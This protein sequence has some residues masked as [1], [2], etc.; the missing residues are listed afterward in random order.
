MRALSLSLVLGGSKD[1]GLCA[2]E[3][4][5]MTFQVEE[6]APGQLGFGGCSQSNCSL[7]I[8]G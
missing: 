4:P 6:G 8:D 2:R 1:R 5:A 3:I 7:L